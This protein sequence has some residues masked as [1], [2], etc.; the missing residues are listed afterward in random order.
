MLPPSVVFGCK[1]C[2]LPAKIGFEKLSSIESLGTLSYHIFF[3]EVLPEIYLLLQKC[4]SMF[5]G[6]L[7]LLPSLSVHIRYVQWRKN[8]LNRNKQVFVFYLAL[9]RKNASKLTLNVS[10]YYPGGLKPRLVYQAP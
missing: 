7:Y 8:V 1:L 6:S 3:L 9:E 10:L 2:R 4:P 5:A